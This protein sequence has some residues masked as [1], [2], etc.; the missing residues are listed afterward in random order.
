[1]Y[2]NYLEKRLFE[3]QNEINSI[4]EE[5]TKLPE[6]ELHIIKNSNSYTKWYAT[7]NK[8]YIYISKKEREYA[9]QLAQRTYLSAKQRELQKE[10]EYLS[11]CINK[12]KS[13]KWKSSQISE[14]IQFAG[15]DS[16]WDNMLLENKLWLCE[17]YEGNPMFR[18]KLI[19]NTLSGCK[20]RSK[21]E[22]IIAD[23]LW[24]HGIP[25]K[26]EAPVIINEGIYYPDF[27]TRHPMTGEIKYWEHFGMMD[28]HKYVSKNM[29]KVEL[30]SENGII[31][32]FNLILT[33]ET[34]NKPLDVNIVERIIDFH[35]GENSW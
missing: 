8:E 25:F 29:S 33:F 27:T 17:P 7:I 28:D 23:A 16:H 14:S 1:M 30:F 11:T 18:E 20:V 24:Q 35:Y 31:P 3:I 4:E 13:I 15:L 9:E 32:S 12:I 5:L 26:Y 34:E 22:V 2:E 19:H 6:G 10:A 21:S